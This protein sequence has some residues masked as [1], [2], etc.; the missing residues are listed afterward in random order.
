MFVVKLRKERSMF[1]SLFICL[2][3]CEN[4]ES[5]LNKRNLRKAAIL[6][7]CEFCEILYD[8]TGQAV[9]GI[10]IQD[11]WRTSGVSLK[12]AGTEA[13]HHNKRHVQIELNSPYMTWNESFCC[14]LMFFL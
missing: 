2:G 7:H 14:F 10:R 4:Y 6:E 11:T 12:H 1:V 13:K 3:L 5:L 9:P 8:S